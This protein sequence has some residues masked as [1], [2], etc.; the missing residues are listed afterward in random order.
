[1]SSLFESKVPNLYIADGHHRLAASSLVRKTILNNKQNQ[2]QES[3]YFLAAAFASSEI[4]VLPYHR[5]IKDLNQMDPNHFFESLKEFFEIRPG[6]IN[7][8]SSHQFGMY[9]NRAWYQLRPLTLGAT[10]QL[11]VNYL[12]DTVLSKILGIHDPST[13]ERIEFIGGTPDIPALE[14]KVN[15]LKAGVAFTVA[16]IPVEK[17]IEIA[18]RGEVLPP[19]S[20]WFEPKLPDGLICHPFRS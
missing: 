5:I 17:I 6:D 13:T 19:K 20:T 4:Q 14:S 16:S 1:M 10:P 8:V 3:Q 12:Q 9:L 18:D 2:S 15:L 11:D 7:P